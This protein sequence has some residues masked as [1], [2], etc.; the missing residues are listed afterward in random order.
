MIARHH[1]ARMVAQ[2]LRVGN[3]QL[4]ASVLASE[5][6]YALCP[7]ALRTDSEHAFFRARGEILLRWARRRG[8]PLREDHNGRF[9][10]V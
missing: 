9:A 6:N 3:R 8:L 7:W 4:A 2:L 1:T 10:A 5:I